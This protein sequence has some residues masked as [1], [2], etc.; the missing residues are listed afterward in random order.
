MFR[1]VC[2]RAFPL[3]YAVTR[4]KGGLQAWFGEPEGHLNW[5]AAC[6]W[7]DMRAPAS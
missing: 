2:W 1:F 6:V 5:P 3:L 7:L 4:M